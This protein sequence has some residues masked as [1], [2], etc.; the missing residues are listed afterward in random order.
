MTLPAAGSSG[1]GHMRGFGGEY[2]CVTEHTEHTE[3]AVT[4]FGVALGQRHRPA[5]I[6]PGR[7]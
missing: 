5:Y 3:H 2:G 1:P 7:K 6:G 4:C